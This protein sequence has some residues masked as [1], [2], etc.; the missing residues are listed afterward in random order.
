MSSY[1]IRR[2]MKR[3]RKEEARLRTEV[4]FE[5]FEIPL[6]MVTAFKYLGRILK[7]SYENWMM[8]VANL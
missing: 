7:E 4:E 1:H 6:E 3:W 8:V 5:A 2:R